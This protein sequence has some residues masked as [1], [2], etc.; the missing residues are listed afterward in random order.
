MRS[1]KLREMHAEARVRRADLDNAER[2]RDRYARRKIAGALV[3]VL[4]LIDGATLAS[5]LVGIGYAASVAPSVLYNPDVDTS[6]ITGLGNAYIWVRGVLQPSRVLV[7][8]DVAGSPWPLL[9]GMR[10][11]VESTISV[12]VA[13]GPNA[14][15][16]MLCY[17]PGDVG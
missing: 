5:G 3:G 7:R 13:S 12:T 10:F 1:T 17:R 11:P 4:E 2:S 6:Y 16:V 14:G 15:A 9:E 8:H